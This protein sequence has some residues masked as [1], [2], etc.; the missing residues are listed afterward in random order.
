MLCVTY[1]L[2]SHNESSLTS[3]YDSLASDNKSS[4]IQDDTLPWHNSLDSAKTDATEDREEAV[5]NAAAN[6]ED[7]F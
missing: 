3:V 2:I 4:S 7:E 6:A 5:K 1:L